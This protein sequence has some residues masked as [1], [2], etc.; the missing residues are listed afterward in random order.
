MRLYILGSLLL[1]VSFA[2]NSQTLKGKVYDSKSTLTNIK[3]INKTQNRLTVTDEEGNFEIQAQINDTLSFE[4]LFYHPKIEIV[5]QFHLNDTFVF[6]LKKIVNEL[7]EVEVK[8]EPKQPVFEEETYNSE[9]NNLI[10]ADIKSNPHLYKPAGENYGVDFI[11][12]IGQV[13]KLFKSKK[14]KAPQYQAITYTQIDSLFKRSSFFN[15]RLAIENL[16]IPKERIHLYY[17][18]CSAKG[19]SSELLKDENRMQLLE[20]FVINSELFLELLDEY[21]EQKPIKD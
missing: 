20:Q 19:I 9:L 15:R 17:D 5:K 4:S 14:Y 13:A 1:L 2:T 12:L 16:K 18:F 11:Y 6:E 8:A 10:K 21:S 3:V 7:N